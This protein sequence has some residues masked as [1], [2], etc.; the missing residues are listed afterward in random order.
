MKYTY[1]EEGDVLYAYVGNPRECAYDAIGNGIYLRKSYSSNE[2]IGFMI[3]DFVK[4]L[5][6]SKDLHKL[7][8]ALEEAV[9]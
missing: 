5:A 4:Q 1:D 8:K 6:E 7:Q 2:Y 3:L 9:K